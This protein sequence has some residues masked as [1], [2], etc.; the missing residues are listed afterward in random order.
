LAQQS[1]GDDTSRLRPGRR[2]RHALLA[3]ASTTLAGLK[4]W[5]KL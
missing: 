5:K 3:N 4:V 2:E 1:H